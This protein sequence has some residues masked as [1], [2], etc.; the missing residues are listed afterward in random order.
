MENPGSQL[1]R[2]LIAYFWE[3]WP[4]DILPRP[5]F[6][7]S[8]DWREREVGS[9]GLIDVLAFASTERVDYTGLQEYRFRF[10]AKW[11]GTNQPGVANPDWNWQKINRLIGV[12][13]AALKVIVQ[14]QFDYKIAARRISACG[15]RLAVF[16]TADVAHA[17]AELAA[18]NDDMRDFHC[19]L[20]R[21]SGAERAKTGDAG[22][23]LVEQR[24]FLAHV[25]NLVDTSVY[26]AL[27]YAAGTLSWEFDG[28]QDPTAWVVQKSPTGV[29]WTDQATISGDQRSH[30]ISGTGTQY[31]R[32]WPSS[33]AITY[34][35]PESNTVKAS[36]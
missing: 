11:P 17:S 6:Y 19:D 20:I 24:N 8:N 33:A 10:D 13:E 28:P 2:A 27:T 25:C 4:T 3:I 1:E 22:L 7:F 36:V 14:G 21:F 5:N 16:G 12:P 32:I 9:T 31:W 29:E 23:F 35:D 18:M 15:R 30:D 26:P 34:L